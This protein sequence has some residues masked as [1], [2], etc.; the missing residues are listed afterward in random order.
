MNR[1][2]VMLAFSESPEYRA[3]IGNEISVTMMYIGMLRRAPDSQGFANWVDYMDRGN[4]GQALIN[5]FLGAS[6]YRQR[7]LP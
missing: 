6:E 1:G 2:Q 5:G 3:F 7:F 4:S